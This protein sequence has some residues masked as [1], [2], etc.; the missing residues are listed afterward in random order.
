LDER[1]GAAGGGPAGAGKGGEGEG[2]GEFG[3]LVS[4]KLPMSVMEKERNGFSK[5]FNTR[6]PLK[7]KLPKGGVETGTLN[8]QKDIDCGHRS[9][10]PEKVN[11][12]DFEA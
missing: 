7:G 3:R 5:G 10:I 9:A 1:E 6:L 4:W 12:C 2:R 8:L 11:T